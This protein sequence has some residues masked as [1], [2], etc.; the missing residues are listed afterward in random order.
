MTT[1]KS[2]RSFWDEKANEN[3]LWFVSSSRPYNARSDADLDEFWASGHKIWAQLKSSI[4]YQP[5]QSDCIV[6]VGCGVGRL[7]RVIAPEVHRLHCFDISDEML[8]IAKKAALPNA[9]FHR[10]EGFG[11]SQLGDSS[12]DLVLAYCVFQHLPSTRALRIYL[13]DMIRVAKPGAFIAFS[14]VPRRATDNLMPLLR[15]RAFLRE[16]LSRNGPRG[17]YRKEWVG[18]RPSAAT[19]HLAC[20]IALTQ[21]DLFGDQWLFWGR[22]PN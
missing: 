6:E 22:K 10:A 2:I 8:A 4:G 16:K 9:I 21:V 12:S 19:V 7:S 5:N 1:V 17:V 15:A 13:S 20:P 14:L 3:A 11:L 18:I